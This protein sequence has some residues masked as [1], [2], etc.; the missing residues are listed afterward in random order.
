MEILEDYR[1][2]EDE[3][4]S[5]MN[6]DSECHL[7]KDHIDFY[8]DRIEFEGE[9]FQIYDMA[10][11]IRYSPFGVEML[12]RVFYRAVSNGYQCSYCF[13]YFHRNDCSLTMSDRSFMK[14]TAS[15]AW[16]C[17]TC[18]PEFIPYE[19]EIPSTASKIPP[20]QDPS[21]SHDNTYQSPDFVFKIRPKAKLDPIIDSPVLVKSIEMSPETLISLIVSM[22]EKFNCSKLAASFIFDLISK[23]NLF[24]F[25][26]LSRCIDN[27]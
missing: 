3:E 17:P 9:V 15:G 24:Y 14:I 23:L 22:I 26:C 2:E 7:C 12:N 18:V 19:C 20:R 25:D 11:L 6:A 10:S 4:T 13:N 8:H 21:Q 27:G 5:L 16:A 1:I